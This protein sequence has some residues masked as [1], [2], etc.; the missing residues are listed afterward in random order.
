MFAIL[1]LLKHPGKRFRDKRQE[2]H[3][4]RESCGL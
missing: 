3:A 4:F 1:H 2:Q